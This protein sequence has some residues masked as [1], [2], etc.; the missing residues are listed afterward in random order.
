MYISWDYEVEGKYF[1]LLP[2][3]ARQLANYSFENEPSLHPSHWLA[4]FSI[5]WIPWFL[6]WTAALY[7][8][9]CT[10]TDYCSKAF[11]SNVWNWL[12]VLFSSRL[13]NHAPVVLLC[14]QII[15]FQTRK[16]HPFFFSEQ[17]QTY[18]LIRKPKPKSFVYLCI[19]S[20]KQAFSFKTISSPRKPVMHS[21]EK[22]V[23][24]YVN[25]LGSQK[26]SNELHNRWKGKCGKVTT[27]TK[28]YRVFYTLEKYFRF[29]NY[30]KIIYH[31]RK[32]VEMF[33][34][35]NKE[36]QI[37]VFNIKNCSSLMQHWK[38]IAWLWIWLNKAIPC[39]SEGESH[40]LPQE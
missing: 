26:K 3:F 13:S 16:F 22:T 25:E 5:L 18:Q 6:Y 7:R 23:S 24:F 1:V 20:I 15:V 40:T 10:L 19:R 37:K 17:I 28:R 11:F 35:F 31:W 21:I 30:M 39:N 9:C 27:H 29:L 14:L 12:F 32:T 33:L 38:C 2:S 34:G 36:N 4:I 8:T